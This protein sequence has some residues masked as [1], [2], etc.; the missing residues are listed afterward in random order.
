MVWVISLDQMISALSFFNP[1]QA[2]YQAVSY[3]ALVT[4]NPNPGESQI[5]K[6]LIISL[7]LI[8]KK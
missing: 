8:K 5:R 6:G 3:W 4:A 7:L 1:S 2:A